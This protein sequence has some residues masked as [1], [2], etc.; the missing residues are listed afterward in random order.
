MELVHPGTSECLTW[1]AGAMPRRQS[2]Y[3]KVDAGE[4]AVGRNDRLAGLPSLEYIDV[5]ALKLTAVC[6]DGYRRQYVGGTRPS[7]RRP[8]TIEGW[9]Q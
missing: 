6:T 2:V 9:Q 1:A 8:S 5:V 7:K 3:T 4:E